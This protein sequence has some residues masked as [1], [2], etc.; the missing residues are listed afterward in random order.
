MPPRPQVQPRLT[1]FPLF[2]ALALPLIRLFLSL[3]PL[4]Q[5]QG[6]NL[7]LPK[8]ISGISS[9]DGN[10]PT[11]LLLTA[12]PDDEVMFFGPTVLNLV[13]AGWDLRGLCLSTG[14]SDGFGQVR[15]QELVA[16]YEILGVPSENVQ[17]VDDPEIRDGMDTDWDP[18][19]V[20]SFVEIYLAT[21]P[22]DIIITFDSLGITSHPNHISVSSSLSHIPI[23]LRPRVLKI[24]SPS[25]ISKFTGP[26]YVFYLHLQ[27]LL[28]R[29]IIEGFFPNLF[30]NESK[31]F[32]VMVNDIPRY[33]TALRAMMAHSSQ[34]VWFRWLYLGASRLMWVNE[35]VEV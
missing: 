15:K 10:K 30:L 29:P 7:L 13:A 23:E 35:L 11:A 12:H 19:L 6:F 34:L 22:V 8:T 2:F 21:N 9:D 1:A 4:P 20:A 31:R 5:P 26:L 14:D 25:I 27:V 33:T 24:R 3:T 32:H 28:S 18:E 16:S 17:I